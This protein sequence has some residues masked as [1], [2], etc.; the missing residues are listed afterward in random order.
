[1]DTDRELYLLRRIEALLIERERLRD[2]VWRHCEPM[3][4]TDEDAALVALCNPEL[5]E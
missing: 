3:A 2:L 5:K 4:M 1:M